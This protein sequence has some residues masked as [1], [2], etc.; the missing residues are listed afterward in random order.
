M[1]EYYPYAKRLDENLAAFSQLVSTIDLQ[2]MMLS[3]LDSSYDPIVTVLTAIA[4][5]LYLDDFCSNPLAYDM[6]LED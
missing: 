5:N 2:H 6:C 4:A 1:D 3:G